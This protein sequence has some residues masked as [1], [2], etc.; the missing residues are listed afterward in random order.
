MQYIIFQQWQFQSRIPQRVAKEAE[1]QVGDL[2]IY[3]D[4][5]HG[6]II[7]VDDATAQVFCHWADGDSSW[8]LM[9]YV[10]AV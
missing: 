2:V 5:T 4:G 9:W 1:M 8:A 7:E 3:R 6:I 10:E